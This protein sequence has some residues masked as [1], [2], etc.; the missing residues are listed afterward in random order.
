VLAYD[1]NWEAMRSHGSSMRSHEVVKTAD[2]IIFL[3]SFL[4]SI[5][6]LLGFWKAI[7]RGLA[8]QNKG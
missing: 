4:K 2:E 3:G 7:N 5:F 1:Q 6:G 8:D